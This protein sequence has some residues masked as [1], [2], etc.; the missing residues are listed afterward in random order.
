MRLTVIG[1][2]FIQ[3]ATSKFLSRQPGVFCSIQTRSSQWITEALVTR[4]LDVG[5]VIAPIDNPYIV[6]EPMLG[7]PV[8]C[9]L[10]LGHS[11][12]AKTVIAIKISFVGG[13]KKSQKSTSEKMTIEWCESE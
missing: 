4:K 11:L 6:A 9:I 3:Q 8:V 2:A 13:R 1:G 5:L 10:P 7:H 12:A